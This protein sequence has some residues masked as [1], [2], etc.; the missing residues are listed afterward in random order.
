MSLPI[1]TAKSR[2]AAVSIIASAGM[3]AAKF[4][5]GIAIGSLALISE[6]LHFASDGFGS[7]AVI[8]GL[9][10]SGLGYAWGDAAAALGVA[11]LISILGLRLGRATIETLLDRAPEGVSDKAAA[12]IR[13]VPGVIDVER[14]RARMVGATHFIDAIVQVP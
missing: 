13:A 5:V 3:A 4:V 6:A 1:A 14:L 9:A 11:V 8:I 12:A 7:T 2:V 10:L